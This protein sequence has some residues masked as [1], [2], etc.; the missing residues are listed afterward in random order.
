M[1]AQLSSIRADGGR[2]AIHPL[3][4]RGRYITWR[5]VAFAVLIAVYLAAPVVQVGGHPAVHLDVAARRFYLMG[6]TFNAQD[7][8]MVLLLATGFVFTA[9]LVTAWRG[10]LWCGWG[11]PQTVFLEAVYRPIERLFDGPSVRRHKLKDQ[12]WPLSRVLRSTGKHAAYLAVSVA[13]AHVATSLFVSLHDLEGMITDGP[14]A[15]PEAFVWTTAFTAV[16]YFDFAWFREQF[17]VVLCPY[18]RLQSVLHDRQSI[19][20]AYDVARGEPRGK[21]A[22]APAAPRGDC[23][24]CKKCVQACPTAIDIRN[25]LQMEC[26]ACAQCIDACDEVMVHIGKPV[27]LIRYASQTELASG[28]RKVLRPRLLLYAVLAT[29][30]LGSLSFALTFR[31]PFEANVLRLRGVP[32]VIEGDRVRNQLEVHLVNKG[33]A[34][35]RFTLSVHGPE[36]LTVD[37]GQR[38]LTL[39]SLEGARVPLVVSL[40]R[41]AA[42]GTVPLELTVR[43]ETLGAERRTTFSFVA[44]R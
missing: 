33:S 44:P 11:C 24:D 42:H 4:V 26:L 19:T 43:D 37:L 41:A 16:L 12:G 18:G 15:H 6:G 14:A 34:S 39:S 3:E 27:G 25:G 20:V 13:L 30:S 28:K 2:L 29:L 17:C 38:E 10:R 7:F 36:G 22:K 21:L 23:I 9:L 40:P 8:W 5:R 35:G 32:F 1:T 31:T